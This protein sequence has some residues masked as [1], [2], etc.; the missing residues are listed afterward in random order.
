MG[1]EH[2]QISPTRV[3]SQSFSISIP[4]LILLLIVVVGCSGDTDSVNDYDADVFPST[5]AEMLPDANMSEGE[6]VN[7]AD[8]P[9]D[10][11]E[12][13]ELS[14]EW[15][16]W[17]ECDCPNPEDMCARENCGL[18]DMEC[19]AEND[20]QCPDGYTC[21]EA[22]SNGRITFCMC[23]GDHEKCASECSTNDDCEWPRGVCDTHAGYCR[24]NSGQEC[25]SSMYCPH[26]TYCADF[27]RCELTGDSEVGDSCEEDEEC[28]TGICH[29]GL[30]DEQC[31]LDE[32]CNDGE[33][34]VWL[35]HERD[36]IGCQ[37]FAECETNEC[38]SNERCR[39]SGDEE[40]CIPQ[41]CLVTG[42][43]ESGDCHLHARPEIMV[44]ECIEPDDPTVDRYCKPDEIWGDGA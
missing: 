2:R 10:I 18:K 1:F 34:C 39:I 37:E 40:T 27:I 30:C 36:G 20:W 29:E 24:H 6:D 4:L 3:T 7:D 33:L 23:T 31:F 16:D 21:Q 32:D 41:G 38:A 19:G 12:P 28:M 15:D 26:G 44:G 25:I 8:S 11:D 13:P 17:Q 22:V 42:D 9:S 14:D 35:G 43:C 5:D